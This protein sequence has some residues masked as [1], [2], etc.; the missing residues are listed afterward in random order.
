M[1]QAM[2]HLLIAGCGYV[3]TALATLARQQRPDLRV[4]GLRRRAHLLPPDILPLAADMQGADLARQL[5]D[6]PLDGVVLA[7]AADQRDAAGYRQTYVQGSRNLLQAL[8]AVGQRP[9]RVVFVSSTAVYAQDDGSWVDEASPTEP[10]HFRGQIMLAAEACVRA[11]PHP[12]C[13]LRLGGIYG[14]GRPLGRAPMG[15]A[16]PFINRIHRDDAAGMLWHILG[17]SA[18]APIYLGTD[19]E[20]ATRRSLAAVLTPDVDLG[21]EPEARPSGK[22]CRNA[23]IRASGYRLRYPSARAS[24]AE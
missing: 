23:A 15:P 22:R 11:A 4:Y 12:S 20:P 14:P 13:V 7:C 1:R 9:R 24:A 3:G 19:D 5:P 17:L 21:S 8:T 6:L 2:G 18:P 16:N 10:S